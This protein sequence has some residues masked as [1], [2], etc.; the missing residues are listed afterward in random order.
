MV[1][2]LEGKKLSSVRKVIAE[3]DKLHEYIREQLKDHKM[4]HNPKS[5]KDF[6]DFYLNLSED[7]R[8][9][10]ALSVVF[11]IYRTNK[12]D[13][14]VDSYTIPAKSIILYDLNDPQIDP[15]VWENPLEFNPDRWTDRLTEP[16]TDGFLPFGTVNKCIST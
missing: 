5:P 4:E 3:N 16:Q 12:R 11:S 14:E 6:L 8:K 15:A 7:T 1:K 10:S 9:D 2:V 13:M